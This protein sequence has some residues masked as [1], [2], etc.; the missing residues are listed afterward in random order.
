M[1]R[2]NRTCEV[3]ANLLI[4]RKYYKLPLPAKRIQNMETRILQ[5][6]NNQK[7]LL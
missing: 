3:T 6:S 5:I 4:A 1:S 2:Q 7:H